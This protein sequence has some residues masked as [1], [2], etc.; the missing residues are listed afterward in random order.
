MEIN[1]VMAVTGNAGVPVHHR[2]KPGNIVYVS[3][4]ETLP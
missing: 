4:V 1:F 2:I 3:T